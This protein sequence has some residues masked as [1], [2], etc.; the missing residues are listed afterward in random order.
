LVQKDVNGEKS[1][2]R[3]DGVR[4]AATRYVCMLDSD[5]LLT[6]TSVA[7]R[8]AVFRDDP[9]FDGVCY[10]LSDRGRRSMDLADFSADPPEGDVLDRYIDRPFV[11]NDGFMLSRDSML[12]YGMYREDL[13]NREDVELLVRLAVRLP[14]RFCGSVVARVR[15]AGASARSDYGK[16]IAQGR[17]MVEH[18]R[19]E[20]D[21]AGRLGGRLDDMEFHDQ[22]ECCRALYKERRYREFR[23][24]FAALLRRRPARMLGRPRFAR[25]YLAS[26]ILRDDRSQ[27]T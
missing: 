27:D 19:A 6:P 21:V 1:A 24:L 18:L 13:T 5:D 10:G 25:R 9:G 22:L 23:R 12:R 4:A 16:I 11:D 8:V 20:P 7:D 15:R 2:A 3:N 14:F 17:R 26:L